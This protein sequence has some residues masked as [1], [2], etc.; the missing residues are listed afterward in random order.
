MLSSIAEVECITQLEV[1]WCFSHD[2]T[3][4]MGFG[5]EDPE[6]KCYSCVIISKVYTIKVTYHC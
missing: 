4:S 1:V 3:E 5:E 2:Q 6:M